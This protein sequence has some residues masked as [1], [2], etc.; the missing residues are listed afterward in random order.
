MKV[1]DLGLAGP[2]FQY[3][4]VVQFPFQRAQFL[5]FE[6]TDFTLAGDCFP[7]A[8]G[9][10]YLATRQEHCEHDQSQTHDGP[11]GTAPRLDTNHDISTSP[12]MSSSRTTENNLPQPDQPQHLLCELIV[13]CAFQANGGVLNRVG[14]NS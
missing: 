8:L 2:D 13:N 5:I 4:Q 10:E 1:L 6:G 12:A 9:C 7:C 3:K 11:E 14:R